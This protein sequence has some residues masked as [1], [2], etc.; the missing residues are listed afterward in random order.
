M[1]DIKPALSGIEWQSEST[2]ETP[3]DDTGGTLLPDWC[4][5][6]NDKVFIVGQVL[7]RPH[8]VAALC[9]YGQPFGFDYDD[10]E[11][12]QAI[13]NSVGDAR[14]HGERIAAKIRALL[15]PTKK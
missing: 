9:L 1:T 4:N 8:A 13:C 6:T 3:D 11:W 15:P 2:C 14:V 12:M 5:R 7:T 10:L